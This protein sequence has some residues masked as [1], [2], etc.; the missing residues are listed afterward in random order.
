MRYRKALS[1]SAAVLSTECHA[2][3][4]DPY[5]LRG[6]IFSTHCIECHFPQGINSL[7]Y[8]NGFFCIIQSSTICFQKKLDIKNT[9]SSNE[10][11]TVNL[12]RPKGTD[13]YKK[14]V[15]SIKL[16]QQGKIHTVIFK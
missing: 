6:T 15:C 13:K 2:L 11:M 12:V 3:S 16:A 1:G 9:Q 4:E 8:V 5:K 10:L 7:N 14:N